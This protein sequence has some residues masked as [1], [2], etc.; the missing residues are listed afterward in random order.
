ML[1]SLASLDSPNARLVAIALICI[2]V[3]SF[4]VLDASAKYLMTAL[5]IPVFQAIWF[6][7]L[8]HVAFTF[9]AF[10]PRNFAVSLRSARPSLQIFRGILLFSTTAL[11]FAALRYLQLDQ[12][13]TLFFLTPFVV[14]ILAGPFLDEW[15]GWRRLLAVMVGFS[16]V[17]LI[18]RPG[19]GGIHWAVIYSF[20]A[21]FCYACYTVLTRYLARHDP[22]LVTQVYSPLAGVVM[23]TPLGLWVWEWPADLWT[24]ALMISTGVSGGFGHYLLILAYRRAPAPILA[25]FAYVGLISQS[26]IGY[27]IFSDV[28]STWTLAGG[29]VIIGSGLYLLYR[30]HAAARAHR[31]TVT[32]QAVPLSN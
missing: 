1:S 21:V 9:V 24:W 17:V 18:T 22:T 10:G 12:I 7:F 23:L 6:R 8:S 2:A 14:A 28:P 4:S 13:A 3:T 30:E 20:G 31:A 5:S 19:F 15:I 26:V 16:G 32:Q 27:L 29:A 11:N 25:P